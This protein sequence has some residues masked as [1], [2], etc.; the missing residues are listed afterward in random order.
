LQTTAWLVAQLLQRHNLPLKRLSVDETRAAYYNSSGNRPKGINDHYACT[1]AFP[2]D[3]G[4]H[5]DVGSEFPW[6]VFMP[7]VQQ[8]LQ[9][10][11]VPK[12]FTITE[13]VE[14]PAGPIAANALYA[15]GGSGFHHVV[16]ATQYGQM[17]GINAFATVGAF[18][19]ANAQ[20]LFGPFLGE[21]SQLAAG[22]EGPA[23]QDGE[24]GADGLGFAPGQ[25]VTVSGTVEVSGA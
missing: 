9:G 6:D 20:A 17:W 3:G 1:Y 13:V 23:G 10:G 16:N 24:P 15:S 25:T 11:N 5:E 8:E 12:T 2:E 14:G 18:T 4:T 19:L 7:M 22:P 21:E